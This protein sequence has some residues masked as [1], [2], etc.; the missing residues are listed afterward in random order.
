MIKRIL[1]FSAICLLGT[2]VFSQDIRTPKNFPGLF[3]GVEW[4]TLSG[5]VGLDYERTI[6]QK[7]KLAIGLKAAHVFKYKLYNLQLLS[8]PDEGTASFSHLLATARYFTGKNNDRGFFIHSGL[9]VVFR[10]H[11]QYDLSETTTLAG[12][13]A[14][15]GFQFFVSQRIAIKWTN[16]LLFAGEGGIT[17]SKISLAF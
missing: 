12:F 3:A 4:N 13:E 11:N 14:G 17:L 6:Y 15:F 10:K 5:L 8:N 9:G 7:Q 1:I 16:S 2:K